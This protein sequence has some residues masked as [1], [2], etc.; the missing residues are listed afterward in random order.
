VRVNWD[1]TSNRARRVVDD[2]H[3]AHPTAAE[4]VFIT[5]GS[6]AAIWSII[7]KAG[8]ALGGTLIAS[9]I[10]A[11]GGFDSAAAKRGIAQSA[12]AIDAI[13]YAF[14]IVPAALM[15]IAAL[16]IWRCVPA[17]GGAALAR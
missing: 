1:G 11:I 3:E 14:G 9:S 8:I 10:L 4:P 6:F 16:I 17:R 7:E 13:R 5:A 2:F 12:E 15:C